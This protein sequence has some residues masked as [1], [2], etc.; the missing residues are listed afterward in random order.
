MRRVI[1]ISQVNTATGSDDLAAIVEAS[2]RRNEADGI[3]GM[4]WTDGIGFAQVLEGD[5]AAVGQTLERILTD[6]RHSNI[7]LVCD[8]AVAGPMFGGWSMK[9]PDASQESTTSEAFLIGYAKRMNGRAARR[10]L[11]IVVA[12]DAQSEH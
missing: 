1:Y 11:E 3:T 9:R 6:P 5:H 12:D 7:E 8:R 4:L 2:A 10:L